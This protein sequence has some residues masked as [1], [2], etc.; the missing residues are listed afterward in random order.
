MQ[1]Q[2]LIL[3]DF[4]EELELTVLSEEK[5]Y[6]LEGMIGTCNGTDNCQCDGDNCQCSTDN[7]QC[8]GGNNCQCNGG[9]NCQC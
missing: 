9:N 2:S 7:C 5:S 3:K 8:I 6:L 1:N 4:V